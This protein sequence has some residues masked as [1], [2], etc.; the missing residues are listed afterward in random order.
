MW[1]HIIWY[2]NTSI[3]TLKIEAADS[4]ETLV[5]AKVHNW[6]SRYQSIQ[7]FSITSTMSFYT[8][9]YIY[10]LTVYEDIQQS[11]DRVKHCGGPVGCKIS[12]AEGELFL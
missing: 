12:A 11:V 6:N 1:Q 8:H 4:S 10:K 7:Y 5:S 9:I 3:S 2:T